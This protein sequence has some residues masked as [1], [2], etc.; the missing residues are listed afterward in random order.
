M[1]EYFSNFRIHFHN[2]HTMSVWCVCVR[3]FR[4]GKMHR[5]DN[6]LVLAWMLTIWDEC[7]SPPRRA[8]R[9]PSSIF[10]L[11]INFGATHLPKRARRKQHEQKRRRCLNSCYSCLAL[12]RRSHIN[13]Q[14]LIKSLIIRFGC[15]YL[16]SR[17]RRPH[18]RTRTKG[19]APR[20]RQ[21]IVIL[22]F[23]LFIFLPR[24][25]PASGCRRTNA[26]GVFC[27]FHL[28]LLLIYNRLESM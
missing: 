28:H 5:E 7:G 2:C 25:A 17:K 19:V 22:S 1:N 21:W 14:K 6:S 23:L 18:A 4:H 20:A 27:R 3:V 12:R 11:S 24:A 13:T 8:H 10:Y 9:P 16:L 26:R 15:I